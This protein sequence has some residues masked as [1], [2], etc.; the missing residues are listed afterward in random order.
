MEDNPF[1]PPSP[2]DDSR[3]GRGLVFSPE[4]VTVVGSLA[5]W[6]RGMAIILYVVVGLVMLGSFGLLM[7]ADM[8]V[9]LLAIMAGFGALMGAAA[10]WLRGAAD[11]F[12]RGVA[13]DDE[14][15]IGQGFRNLRT[16]LVLVGIFSVLSLVN[17]VYQVIG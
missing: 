10:T 7:T 4:G 17:T 16:Y 9:L 5:T 12:E 15:T 8:P 13:S 2:T 3:S 14:M 11:G 6:M 1:A